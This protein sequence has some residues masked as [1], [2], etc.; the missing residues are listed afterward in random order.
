MPTK[1]FGTL[2]IVVGVFVLIG[3][4]CTAIFSPVEGLITFVIGLGLIFYGAHLRKT[5][6]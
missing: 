3:G 5:A 2:C 4:G 6:E 1:F